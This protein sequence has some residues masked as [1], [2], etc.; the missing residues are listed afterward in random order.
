MQTYHTFTLCLRCSHVMLGCCTYRLRGRL[1]WCNK[2]RHSQSPRHYLRVD[3]VHRHTSSTA[4][5]RRTCRPTV[6]YTTVSTV[7]SSIHTTNR[8]LAH[9]RHTSFLTRLTTTI[10]CKL[11]LCGKQWTWEK[12]FCR[13]VR[14]LCSINNYVY[15]V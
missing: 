12:S 14:L 8:Y 13:R 10:F 15:L 6:E 7:S 11:W 3:S 1:S 2:T 4:A 5:S 9:S